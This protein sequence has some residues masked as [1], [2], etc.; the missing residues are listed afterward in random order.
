MKRKKETQQII[1]SIFQYGYAQTKMLPYQDFRWLD[2][3]EG[4]KID[5]L[6]QSATQ[7]EGFI[8]ECDLTYPSRLHKEH[9]SFPCAP[10]NQD[11][12][13]DTL[14]PQS[15]EWLHNIKGRKNKAYKAKKLTSTFLPKKKYIVH[16]MALKKYLELGLKCTKVHRVLTFKQA[17]F[18]APYIQ[19]CAKLRAEE[20]NKFLQ[21]CIKLQCNAIYGKMLQNAR[22]YIQVKFAQTKEALAKYQSSPFF[23]C[24]KAYTETFAAVF[25]R[26]SIVKMRQPIAVGLSILDLSKEHM[27]SMYYNEIIPSLQGC[28]NVELLTTDTDSFLL[29]VKGSSVNNIYKSLFPII[30]FS[31]YDKNHTLHSNEIK[32]ELGYFKNELE[33]KKRIEEAV[34]LRSKCYSLK[35]QNSKSAIRKA[36]EERKKD[37]EVKFLKKIEKLKKCKGVNAASLEYDDYKKVLE[38]STQSIRKVN[39]LQSHDHQIFTIQQ[40]KV[41]FSCFDDKRY[42][43]C[44]HHSVPYGDIRITKYKKTNVCFLCNNKE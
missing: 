1:H 37:K 10:S 6:K 9:A 44:M 34:C 15:Q 12:D 22:N 30:D 35:L 20:P 19:L 33:G 13:F 36:K 3:E 27:Y 4:K 38:D 14:S 43:L 7:N 28:E 11:I 29:N 8:V 24:T 42:Y 2:K 17:D 39:K 21:K 16:Y 18:I 32:G 25:L 40:T 41:C 23:E 26:Q 31:N 5:W